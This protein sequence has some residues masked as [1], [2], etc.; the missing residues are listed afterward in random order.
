MAVRGLHHRGGWIAARRNGR[1]RRGQG[2]RTQPRRP[3]STPGGAAQ[4]RPRGIRRGAPCRT[5]RAGHRSE[6]GRGKGEAPARPA[7][8]LHPLADI[9]E[10][11]I[12]S[13]KR[14][15]VAVLLAAVTPLACGQAYPTKPV[16][17]ILPYAAGGLLE[18][19][20][21]TIGQAFSEQVGQPLVI[22]TR[23]GGNTFI[24]M[25]ACKDAAPDGHTICIT[26]AESL[27]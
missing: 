12:M 11:V 16:R 10:E 17:A 27:S 5:G 8:C 22:E 2:R 26:T 20:V 9:E 1:P 18:V 14:L 21:R 4:S 25:Q 7:Y 23:P 3:Q 13:T 24:G 15:G 19:T 6:P